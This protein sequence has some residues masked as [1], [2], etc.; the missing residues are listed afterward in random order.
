MQSACTS[1]TSMHTTPRHPHV[2]TCLLFDECDIYGPQEFRLLPHW[3]SSG[4][5]CNVDNM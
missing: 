2:V 1:N 5:L 4:S 3:L